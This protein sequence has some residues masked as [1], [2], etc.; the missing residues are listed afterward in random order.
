MLG[1]QMKAIMK[2]QRRLEDQIVRANQSTERLIEMMA[3]QLASQKK[4]RGRLGFLGGWG[5]A[6]VGGIVECI[7]GVH[8]KGGM[9]M[10]SKGSWMGPRRE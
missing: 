5:V 2:E 4:V 8:R 6:G 9:I 1:H 3:R 10:G 7:R